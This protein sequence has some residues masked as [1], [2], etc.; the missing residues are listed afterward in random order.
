[1]AITPPE[2][3]IWWREPIAR[4]ELILIA[5]AFALLFWLVNYR[6]VRISAQS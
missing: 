5:V 1:M 4:T 3:R 2:Q 6:F